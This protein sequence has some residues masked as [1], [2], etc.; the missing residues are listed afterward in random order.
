MERISGPWAGIFIAAY[1]TELAGV[2]YGYAKLCELRPADVW[3]AVPVVKVASRGFADEQLALD[4]VERR[5]R[6]VI[7]EALRPE[8]G[9]SFLSSLISRLT[10]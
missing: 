6:R 5:A 2:F 10:S 1:T 8:P 7:S 4:S 9:E 3:S